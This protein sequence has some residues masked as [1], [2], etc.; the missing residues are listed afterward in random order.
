MWT[1]I[2]KGLT[3]MIIIM[4]KYDGK[5]KMKIMTKEAEKVKDDKIKH[6]GISQN[7][8]GLNN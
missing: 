4:R 6:C 2:N 7:G 8:S 3:L 1:G 5:V